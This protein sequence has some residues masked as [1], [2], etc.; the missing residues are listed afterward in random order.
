MTQEELIEQLKGQIIKNLSLE[1]LTPGDI[2]A[3]GPLFGEG[4]GLDSIDAIELVLLLE[5]EYGI[6]VEDP[7]KRR[8]VL[9]SIRT[10]AKFIEANGK[11]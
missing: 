11:A 2:D 10:M 5:K 1:D 6:K 8:E 7:R 9:T 3:D 4:L